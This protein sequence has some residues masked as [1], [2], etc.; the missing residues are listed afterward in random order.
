MPSKEELKRSA[1]EIIDSK[2]DEL[3]AL[4]KTI[5]AHPE[6]GF[7]EVKT[8]KLVAEQFGALGLQPRRGLAVTGVRADAS[9]TAP[10]PTLEILV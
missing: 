5:L 6:P 10:G 8:A 9:G 4:A 2:A 1:A 3:V 7:R